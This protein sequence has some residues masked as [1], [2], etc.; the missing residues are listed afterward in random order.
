MRKIRNKMRISVKEANGKVV[1]GSDE[2]RKRQGK[3]FE[4]LLNV[5]DGRV[6]DVGCLVLGG[7]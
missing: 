4:G 5:F 1:T 6:E 3:N 2:G 7:M